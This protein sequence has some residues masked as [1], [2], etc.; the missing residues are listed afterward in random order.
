[1]ESI[2][3]FDRRAAMCLQDEV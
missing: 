1:V 2:T 3:S